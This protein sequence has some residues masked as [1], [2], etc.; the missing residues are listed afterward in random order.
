[1][2]VSEEDKV[3]SIN[4]SRRRLMTTSA[5]LVAGGLTGCNAGVAS[6]VNRAPGEPSTAV[7]PDFNAERC[8]DQLTSIVG[9]EEQRFA[10]W[11]ETLRASAAG[12]E[13]AFVDLNA[14]D[15]NMKLVGKRL[16][17]RIGLRLCA[18]SLPSLELLEYMMLAACTNRIMAFSEGMV[19]D[20]LLRFGSGVDILL[21][22][23]ATVDALNRTFVTLDE[24]GG[25][26]PNPSGSVRW[27]VDTPRRM[28][29]FAEFAANR[30]TRINVSVEIDVGL[31]RGGARNSEQLLAM[32]K[33]IDESP[34]LQ[35][36]GF[37]GYEGHVPFVP[38][39]RST[40]AAEFAAVQSRYAE[41]VREGKGAY[42][43]LFEQPL[44]YNSGGSRTY[45]L[46]TDDLDSPV[47]EVAMGSAFFY[48]SNFH[49][50]PDSELRTATFFATPVLKRLDPAETYPDP[51]LLPD[52]AAENSDYEVWFT[53]VSGGFPGSQHYPK[54]LVT[55]PTSSSD[56]SRIVNMMPNQ[57]RWMGSR[58][59][60]LEEGDFIFYQ[61]W[62]AD[63]VRWLAYLDVFRGEQL[64]DQWP[65]FQPGIQ[66]SS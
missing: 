14:V 35:F 45:H 40:P 3:G 32:L 29:E 11:N 9:P 33:T 36:T 56:P 5:A 19:R 44:V 48:P 43:E 52:L 15:Y 21:G 34:Y 28:Q 10:A 6:S 58:E 59:V 27:L 26:A 38:L 23:P 20:L 50:L 25:S 51:D 61:P 31:R 46:Y 22:R 53:M 16:G 41:F 2:K 37:M 54:G 12:R 1:M 13:S 49:N 4:Q 18:K 17:S 8:T 65:T 64:V 60:P 47:N 62:E 63:A 7:L 30:H 39:E 57:G 42:P 24:L 55:T 66:L